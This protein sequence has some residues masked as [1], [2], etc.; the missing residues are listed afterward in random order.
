[1]RKDFQFLH[2]LYLTATAVAAF[3][4]FAMTAAILSG[5]PNDL[6]HLVMVYSHAFKVSAVA[7]LIYAIGKN[8]RED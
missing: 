3:G 8:M 6:R 7:L 5:D 1:M 2:R 4:G